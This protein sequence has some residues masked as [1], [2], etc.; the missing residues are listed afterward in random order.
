MNNS[1]FYRKEA[2]SLPPKTSVLVFFF[3]TAAS[4]P[5]LRLDVDVC[6]FALVLFGKETLVIEFCMLYS[7]V[8]ISS[9]P[10]PAAHSSCFRT[11]KMY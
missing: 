11:Q 4:P 3:R 5:A 6:L 1:V 7:E 8:V 9:V 10:I 2:V